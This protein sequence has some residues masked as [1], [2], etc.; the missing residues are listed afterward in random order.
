MA[1]RRI[2]NCL[3]LFRDANIGLRSRRVF[4][5]IVGNSRARIQ[6][7]SASPL[8]PGCKT[9]DMAVFFIRRE[10]PRT[11]FRSIMNSISEVN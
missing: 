7:E 4:I 1:V 6:A 5:Y 8:H 3:S 9:I 10:F 11:R 2:V